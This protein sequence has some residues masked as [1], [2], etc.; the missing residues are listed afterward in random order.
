MIDFPIDELFDEQ[1]STIWLEHNLHSQGLRCPRCQCADRRIARPGSFTGYRCKACDRYYTILTGTI[2]SCE[3]AGAGLRT[4]LRV[5][6]GVHKKYLARYVAVYRVMTNAKSI[7][8]EI[9]RNICCR[10]TPLQSKVT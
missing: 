4:Y 3:G 10:L 5:F 6:R 7:S 2:F 9:I 8:V 1:A